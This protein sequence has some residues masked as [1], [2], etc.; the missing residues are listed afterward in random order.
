MI[1]LHRGFIAPTRW[2]SCL[3]LVCGK[4]RTR[5]RMD[6]WFVPP[7]RP[8][9]LLFS[10]VVL[11]LQYYCV[12]SVRSLDCSSVPVDWPGAGHKL[13]SQPPRRAQARPRTIAE[14]QGS[15]R[16]SG[17]LPPFVLC[18]D[19]VPSSWSYKSSRFVTHR[20]RARSTLVTGCLLARMQSRQQWVL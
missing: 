9:L 11:L 12:A 14:G 4:M 19:A 6:M 16:L 2:L 5:K 15:R 20:S 8:C 17:H 10:K 1:C 3:T 13:C 7:L 18:G